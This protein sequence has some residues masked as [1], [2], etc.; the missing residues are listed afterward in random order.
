[1]TNC[2]KIV[3]ILFLVNTVLGEE[4]RIFKCV[5]MMH[6]IS[7]SAISPSPQDA[8]TLRLDTYKLGEQIIKANLMNC[9][10]DRLIDESLSKSNRDEPFLGDGIVFIFSVSNDRYYHV[11]CEQSKSSMQSENFRFVVSSLE[12]ISTEPVFAFLKK[13]FT[14]RDTQLMEILRISLKALQT[15]PDV[16]E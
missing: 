8:D 6:K 3:F 1:M 14:V 10:L 2:V 9:D 11:F 15:L 12:K 7:A 5:E 16:S 13:G 4:C